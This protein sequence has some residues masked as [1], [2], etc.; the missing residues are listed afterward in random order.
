MSR[1]RL[2]IPLGLVA[3]AVAVA[4]L[5]FSPGTTTPSTASGSTAVL[6]ASSTGESEGQTLFENNCSSCH[7]ADAQGSSLAPNLHG[8][9]AATVDL[10][11][12]SGWMPLANPASQPARKPALFTT[13]Q[14]LAIAHF[15]ASLDHNAG[16]AIPSVN[17][18]G[19]NVA[20]GQDLFSLN[21]APCHTITGAG[22]ALSNGLYAPPLHGLTALQVAEA[23]ETG[24]GN[25][26]R[27]G[28]GVIDGKQ[29]AD[30]VAYVTEYIEKPTNPGG[31][32][33]G[34]VGP[35]AEG[36]VGLFLGVGACLL[37]ALWVGE[38]TKEDDEPHGHDD[39]AHSEVAHV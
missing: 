18:K 15:V 28:A 31:L 17:L 34:G 4:L 19:A 38:R 1:R 25:M 23:I 12:G 5:V 2:L 37:A 16:P 29:A 22:D 3:A 13:Q 24:P 30:V 27:F 7:G 8:V 20:E 14:T 11:V 9:G 10:W 32:G 26:P 35:V 36:F 6:T 21:C 39:D 33:L